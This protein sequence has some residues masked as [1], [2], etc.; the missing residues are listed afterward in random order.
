MN[1]N[2]EWG[3][4]VNCNVQQK[5]DVMRSMTDYMSS[6]SDAFSFSESK[7]QETN[8]NVPVVPFL[9]NYKEKKSTKSSTSTSS[10]YKN[11][12]KFFESVNGEAYINKA[13]CIVYKVSINPFSRPVFTDGFKNALRSLQRAAKKP[14]SETSK[15]IRSEFLNQYGTHYQSE[16]YLGASMTTITRISTRSASQAESNRRKECVSN[17]YSEG[18]SHGVD[19]NEVDV[20][21]SV[22]GGNGPVSGSVSA[23]TTVGGWGVGSENAYKKASSKC[24]SNA[25][26]SSA[27]ASIGVEQTEIISVGVSPYTAKEQ[28]VQAI[29]KAPSSM[30]FVL[31]NITNLLTQNNV[32]HIPL[33]EFNPDGEKLN[34]PKIR[35]F[36]KLT[37]ERYCNITLGY[38]CPAPKSCFIWNNCSVGQ[39]CVDDSSAEAGFH[40]I[41]EDF[42]RKGIFLIIFGSKHK[43]ILVPIYFIY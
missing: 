37:V 39:R 19:V 42:Y 5:T 41:N 4:D 7:S 27:F 20:S 17:A 28:W 32:N 38:P 33:D 29:R 18:T 13:Q 25:D 1:A 23:S 34:A 40:C 10:D 31:T 15:K 11:Q 22:S 43:I 24:D 21:A 36:L 35:R 8:K 30:K 16:C 26:A 3:D 6:M 14:N 2:F 12:K 9:V